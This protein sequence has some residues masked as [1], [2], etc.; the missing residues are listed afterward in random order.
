MNRNNIIR[1][2]LVIILLAGLSLTC[3][4]KNENQQSQAEQ[5]LAVKVLL[6]KKTAQDM[7]K[8]YTGSLEGEKQADIY[9]KLAESVENI[10][11]REG[12]RVTTGQVLISLDRLGPSSR[13]NETRSL[14]LNAE[15]N[16]TKMDYLYKEG[17][18]A[19]S[20][21]DAAKTEYEVTRANFEAVS[22][23]VDIQSPITGIVTVINVSEGDFVNIGQK[24]A[25]VASTDKLRVKF[26]VNSDEI[27]YLKKG[28]EVVVSSTVF[29]YKA[30]G[31]IVSVASSADPQ[32]RSFQIEVILDNEE[33]L[34]KPG[35]FVRVDIIL[36]RLEN[37]ILIPRSAVLLLDNK[38]TVFVVSNNKAVKRELSVGPEIDGRVVITEGLQ[39]N[40]TL[41]ILGQDYLQE[42]SNV[43]ITTWEE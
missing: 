14:F 32:T 31:K 15:K 41:V 19:E 2:S 27:K 11:V 3:G 7:V 43:K 9:A 29:N 36:E 8:T 22:K 21:F 13:Y 23:L 37:V 40:D 1:N 30:P 39:E 5:V 4:N 20:Q 6:T 34:F 25:T 16:Y 10:Q 28:A 26:G 38:P 33:K 42:G 12:D 18:I 35:M 24:L 17:A